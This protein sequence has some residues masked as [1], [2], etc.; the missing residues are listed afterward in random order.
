MIE[1]TEIFKYLSIAALQILLPLLLIVLAIIVDK[2]INPNG[3]C[4]SKEDLIEDLEEL[5]E[6]KDH[7]YTMDELSMLLSSSTDKEVLGILNQIELIRQHNLPVELNDF[8][9]AK[10]KE[11]IIK[12]IARLK[13]GNLDLVKS[14]NSTVSD[15]LKPLKTSNSFIIKFSNQIEKLSGI[16]V[17]VCISSLLLVQ[18]Y[19]LIDPAERA[20]YDLNFYLVA[21]RVSLIFLLALSLLELGLLAKLSNFIIYLF[22]IIATTLFIQFFHWCLS[23]SYFNPLLYINGYIWINLTGDLLERVFTFSGKI[24]K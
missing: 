6:E 17:L 19:Y 9:D 15:P 23:I 21:F 20:Y 8:V 16:F 24:K 7:T 10:G 3:Y 11:Q 5:L 13:N 12:L 22:I 14:N 18:H 4:P 1:S 2:L